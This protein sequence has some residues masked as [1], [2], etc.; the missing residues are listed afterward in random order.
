MPKPLAICIEDM[1]SESETKYMRC[2]ALAGRQPGLR[3]DEAGRVLWRSDESAACELWVSADERLILYRLEGALPITLHRAGRS[4]EVPCSKPVVVIDQDRLDMGTRQLRI[5]VHGEAPAVAAPQALPARSGS[6]GRLARLATTAAVIGAVVTAGGCTDTKTG[7]T[8]TVDVREYPPVPEPPTITPSPTVE[9]REFPP[10]VVEPTATPSSTIEVREM[11][12]TATAAPPTIEV[13]ETPPIAIVTSPTIEAS[14][15]PTE[16]VTPS[17]TI[18]VREMP[19]TPTLA[20][21]D[22]QP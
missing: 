1:D 22:S 20:P 21:A 12:P 16:T 19:P 18:E 2:V 9:V 15:T 5:H 3:L 17:P 4:L 11:P 14:E 8:P 10:E 13:L 7:V 6:L